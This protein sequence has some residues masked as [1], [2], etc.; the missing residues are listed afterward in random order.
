M[1]MSLV[2]H[3]S[4]K[5]ILLGSKKWLQRDD[6][7]D[8]LKRMEK[9]MDE[10]LSASGHLG[11][12]P[13]N[14]IGSLGTHYGMVACDAFFHLDN[15]QLAES[16]NRAV[17][18]NLLIFRWDAMYS[19]LRQDLG[20]WPQQ[21]WDSLKVAGEVTLSNWDNAKICAVRFIEMAEKDQRINTVRGSRRV[22]QGTNDVFLIYLFCQVFDLKT[23]FTPPKPLIPE[24][25]HV[26]D[27]WRTSDESVF[28]QAMQAAAEFHISRSKDHTTLKMYEFTWPF[29][30]V[31]PA[32]L[33]AIQALRCR[34]GLPA[35]DTDHALIDTPWSIIK[36]LPEVE[37]HPL[38]VAVEARLKKDYPTF[39]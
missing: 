8:A 2:F 22:K 26:L 37:P 3:P 6:N 1:H 21:Y 39:R 27:S 38:I 14:R 4:L 30:R 18:F 7:I 16:L 13:Y 10:F 19:E 29:D 32:E 9:D 35:F 34:D 25:Q 28:K 23:S 5:K 36:D 11:G 24:Y 31:F 12:R 33:L 15:H 17:S 20:N